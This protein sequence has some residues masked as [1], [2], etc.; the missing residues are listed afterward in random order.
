MNVG[1][2]RRKSERTLF[3]LSIRLLCNHQDLIGQGVDTKL[4]SLALSTNEKLGIVT[5]FT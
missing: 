4:Y 2:R 1:R 5:R 3:A